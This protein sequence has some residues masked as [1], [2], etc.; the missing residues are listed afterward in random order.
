M[1][2]MAE[3]ISNINTLCGYGNTETHTYLRN[4]CIQLNQIQLTLLTFDTKILKTYFDFFQIF[5][6][7]SLF[8]FI[9]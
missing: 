1:L 3:N 7:Y 8:K 2:K 4:T 6:H 9:A 5:R